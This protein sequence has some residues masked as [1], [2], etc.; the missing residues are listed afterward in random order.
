MGAVGLTVAGSKGNLQLPSCHG[1]D[2]KEYGS[3]NYVDTTFAIPI[4]KQET[5][6]SL[7]RIFYFGI[8]ILKLYL[9]LRG[10]NFGFMSNGYIFFLLFQLVIVTTL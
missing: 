5:S 1:G 3:H 2:P 6:R 7:T 4:P 8:W 9:K 10:P